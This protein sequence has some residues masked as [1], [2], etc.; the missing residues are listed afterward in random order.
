MMEERMG[1]K[2]N[3]EQDP[4]MLKGIS[5]FCM[6]NYKMIVLEGIDF[7]TTLLSK[8]PDSQ[9]KNYL[10]YYGKNYDITFKNKK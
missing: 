2:L 8:H 3:E 5:A 6:Y 9:Y 1:E 4:N 10:E 7:E